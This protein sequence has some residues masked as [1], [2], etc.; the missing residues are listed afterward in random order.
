MSALD[1]DTAAALDALGE[2]A[3][4]GADYVPGPVEPPPGDDPGPGPSTVEV[5]STCLDVTFAVVAARAGDHWKLSADE[6]DMLGGALAAVVDKYFPDMATGPEATL[7]M[8]AGILIVPR[9]MQSRALA[10]AHQADGDET[11][12][13][14]PR[15]FETIAGEQTEGAADAS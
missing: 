4:S 15:Q 10:V 12:E 2:S 9:V 6:L 3:D 7:I 8:V 1:A 11:A 14:T 13:D 5:C